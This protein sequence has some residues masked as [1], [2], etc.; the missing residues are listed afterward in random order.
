MLGRF[1]RFGSDA[2]YF[3]CSVDEER[4]LRFFG[5]QGDYSEGISSILDCF[6]EALFLEGF[7]YSSQVEDWF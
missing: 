5:S 4:S 2:D 7:S 3:A 1:D 6:E